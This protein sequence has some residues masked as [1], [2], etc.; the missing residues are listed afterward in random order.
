MSGVGTKIRSRYRRAAFARVGPL[1]VERP[2]LLEME[3]TGVARATPPRR[4]PRP[5]GAAPL[6]RRPPAPLTR[7][8]RQVAGASG[9]VVG[10]VGYDLFRRAVVEFPPAAKAVTSGPEP[11]SI[12]LH[13]PAAWAASPPSPPPRWLALAIISNVPHLW[14]SFAAR[15]PDDAPVETGPELMMLDSGAGGSDA[16]F[17]ARA[18]ER[19]GLSGVGAYSGASRLVGV[20]ASGEARASAGVSTQKR[21]LPAITFLP[22]P[23]DSR[24]VAAGGVV[25]EGGPRDAAAQVRFER[26]ETQ[27]LQLTAAFDLSEHMAGVICMPLLARR[28]VLLDLGS[29]RMAFVPGEGEGPGGE[30]GLGEW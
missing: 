23:G 26:I 6:W 3:L 1:R 22:G 7:A 4:P 16:I 11:A 13:C 15:G 8:P 9:P 28:R 25:Q 27:L 24:T 2:I 20:S 14:A 17:H 19:L 12:L 21:V 5:P 30:I 29:R 18:V 10:I